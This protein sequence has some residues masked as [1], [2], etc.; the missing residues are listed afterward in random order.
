MEVKM[1]NR[2]YNK[3][4]KVLV[5]YFSLFICMLVL[6]FTGNTN[7]FAQ[8]LSE[9]DQQAA[10]IQY[11]LK[12]RFTPDLK[13]GD[14]VK[15]E[16]TGEGAE[17][18]GIELKVTGEEKGN[19]W[20]EE[21]FQGVEVQYLVDLKQMKLIKAKGVDETGSEFELTLLSD[22]K[23]D[24]MMGMFKI[25]MEQQG[26]YAQFV[27]WKEGDKTEELVVPGG[28]F[29][30]IYLR[31]EYAEQYAKQIEDYKKLLREQGKTDAEIDAAVY[32]NEPRLYFSDDVPKML[33]MQIAIGWV[34]YIEA[35]EKITGGLIECKHMAPIRLTE[36]SGQ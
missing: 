18:A 29:A 25:Q 27:S 21:K 19:F 4:S 35:F 32:G 24:E 33:P 22:E 34:P 6:S 20:I 17:G 2:N 30:C 31:P 26:S 7:L 5:Y 1:L 23:L 9:N 13:V 28:T 36:Y 12:Y 10:L 16:I 3:K 8:D 15:Y 14:W 11:T